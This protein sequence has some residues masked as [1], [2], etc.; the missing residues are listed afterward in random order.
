MMNKINSTADNNNYQL[1]DFSLQK[2]YR[3]NKNLT[4]TYTKW[5]IINEIVL[6]VILQMIN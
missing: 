4:Q 5:I 3:I 2:N 1:L 6:H